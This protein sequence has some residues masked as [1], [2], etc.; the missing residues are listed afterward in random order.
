VVVGLE[1]HADCEHRRDEAL[2]RLCRAGNRRIGFAEM[3]LE[4][5]MHAR[6]VAHLDGASQRLLEGGRHP[7]D[8]NVLGVIGNV[9]S[10]EIAEVVV[11]DAVIGLAPG[12]VVQ[13]PLIHR[14][15]HHQPIR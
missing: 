2:Q 14:A 11:P 7:A 3:R 13:H 4:P 8:H 1:P 10:I 5:D 15:R 12:Q 9:R 6:L